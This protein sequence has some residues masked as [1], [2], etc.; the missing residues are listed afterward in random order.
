MDGYPRIRIK[1]RNIMVHRIV[2]HLWL[3]VK[4][5][6]GKIIVR[7]CRNRL[8]LNPN[9]FEIR[10][11][12][13]PPR[14][15]EE[16]KKVI[17]ENIEKDPITGCWNWKRTLN[18]SGYPNIRVK[19]KTV[20]VARVMAW[21]FKGFPLG[22]KLMIRHKCDNRK[23]VNPDHLEWGTNQ[24]NMN[25]MKQRGRSPNNRGS[26]N[27]HSKLKEEDVMMIREL[28]RRGE[29]IKDL[30]FQ[31]RVTRT[32]I[33]DVIHG[34]VWK[35]LPGAIP[36][37]PQIKYS[38]DQI[39]DMLN[40]LKRGHEIKTVAQEY[41]ISVSHLRSIWLGHKRKNVPGPR[42]TSKKPHRVYT[43]EQVLDM[44]RRFDNGE[45]V[46]SIRKDYNGNYKTIEA[47][48]K[49][50]SWKWLKD[51]TPPENEPDDPEPVVV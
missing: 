34:K 27:P 18:S 7:K 40:G 46:E 42:A 3:G 37:D 25:D 5:D 1:N 8:C 32:A 16:L 14:T 44:R 38:D 41:G 4:L 29:S 17:L 45:S 39:K 19:G 43:K 30:A 28:F 24:D 2:A 10:E 36:R 31:Y 23:C 22:S 13:K 35:H 11:G 20:S 51:E 12:G 9:H 49:R 33:S 48:C 26:R 21:I 47:I 15:K 50:R 6:S